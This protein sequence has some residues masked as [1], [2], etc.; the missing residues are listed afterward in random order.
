MM[1]ANKL[2]LKFLYYY[3]T[4]YIKLIV[5]SYQNYF[6][7]HLNDSIFQCFCCKNLIFKQDSFTTH[8]FFVNVQTFDTKALTFKYDLKMQVKR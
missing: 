6:Y 8:F 5:T 1:I 3:N 2:F 7:K 4:K